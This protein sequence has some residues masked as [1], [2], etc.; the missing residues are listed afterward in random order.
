VD[1][2]DCSNLRS[3]KGYAVVLA[4]VDESADLWA[5]NGK[6]GDSYKTTYKVGAAVWL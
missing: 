1:R 5:T 6:K 4:T 2:I 3:G